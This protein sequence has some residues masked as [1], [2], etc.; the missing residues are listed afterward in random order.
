MIVGG[1]LHILQESLNQEEAIIS[2][3]GETLS[4]GLFIAFSPLSL[5]CLT[6]PTSLLGTRSLFGR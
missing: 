2:H 3:S 5:P 1:Q 4:N 6:F